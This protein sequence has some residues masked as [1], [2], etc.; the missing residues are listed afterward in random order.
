MLWGD[1]LKKLKW[2]N[3]AVFYSLVLCG[4]IAFSALILNACFLHASRQ[5][6]LKGGSYF[7]TIILDAGHGG[8][9]SGAVG[10]NNVLE[11]DINLD[12]VI[13]LKS[14]FEV[15]GFNIKMTR[16]EDESIH[17][18]NS[19]TIR[20][21]KVSD[22]KNR[23]SMIN[24]DPSNLLIS[25]HQNKFEDSKYKGAQVFYSKNNPQSQELAQSI[26]ASFL[27]F[28]Q[29]DNNREIK[30]SPKG[31]FLLNKSTVPAVIVECGFLSNG[32]DARNLLDKKYQS[33]L[34][35]AIFCGFLDYWR[36]SG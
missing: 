32:E 15:S 33:K 18:E 24:S 23:L 25:V 9:D 34:A 7:P 27:A 5:A 19:N 10:L 14:L 31:V 30:P 11:K 6:S 36:K 17:S 3:D 1:I 20:S 13:K 21:K 12:I 2:G 4:Y 35:F 28:I 8:V 29:K 22:L 16:D 26:R